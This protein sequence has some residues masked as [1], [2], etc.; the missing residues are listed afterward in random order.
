MQHSSRAREGGAG[1]DNQVQKV[2]KAKP[3][4]NRRQTA[5]IGSCCTINNRA[6]DKKYTR[7]YTWHQSARADH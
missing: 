5:C 2:Q 7:T 4:S 3:W 6:G 1:K